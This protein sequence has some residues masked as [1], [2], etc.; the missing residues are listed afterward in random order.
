MST[1][2]RIAETLSITD[3]FRMFPDEDTC[4]AWLEEVRWGGT[5]VCPHCGGIENI[6]KPKS[7]KYTYWHR[8]CRSNF[9]V[10]TKTV[11]HSSNASSQNW[12]IAMY[13]VLTA[14]KGVSAMQLSKELGVTYK[15]AWYMLH[16]IREACA[17]GDFNF[18]KVVEVD[19]TYIGGKE[20]NKH[21]SKKLHAGRGP[22][23]KTPVLGV[24]ERGGKV[25]AKPVS[26]VNKATVAAFLDERVTP[27]ATIYSDEA[28]VYNGLSDDSVN[29]GAGEYVRDD[30][31]T[32]TMEGVWS[33]FK[34]SITGTWHHVSPKHLGRYVNEATFR[35]NE[36]NCQVDTLDRMKALVA[37]FGGRK[38]G[39][40]NLTA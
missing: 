40:K 34:R 19:E 22:V 18:S 8:D 25:S 23:G 3:L 17:S 2:K 15:T 16:R 36:G 30:V 26:N 33:I 31:H 10:K 27:E 7:K 12:L 39:Y 32:N 1:K 38:V 14:R 6:T 29:H 35:L 24:V 21:E 13:T 28:K 37:S 4:V 11:M 20:G 5:P 9:T